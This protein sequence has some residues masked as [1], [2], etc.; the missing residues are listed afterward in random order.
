MIDFSEVLGGSKNPEAG[1]TAGLPKR[2]AIEALSSAERLQVA[3]EVLSAFV[4]KVQEHQ[5]SGG[6]LILRESEAEVLRTMGEVLLDEAENRYAQ[7]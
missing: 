3:S 1:S 4:T 2:P 7:E 6:E 5:R